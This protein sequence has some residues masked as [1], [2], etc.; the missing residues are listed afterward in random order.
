MSEIV[1]SLP[2]GVNIGIDCQ[3]FQEGYHWTFNGQ[4]GKVILE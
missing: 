2:N 1:S 3:V 4:T